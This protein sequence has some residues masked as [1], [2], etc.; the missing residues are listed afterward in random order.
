MNGDTRAI[1]APGA[2]PALPSEPRSDDD[3]E[4][5]A[6]QCARIV[7]RYARTFRIASRLLPAP[8]RRAAFAIYAVCRTADDIVDASGLRGRDSLEA[9]RRFRD[10]AF[11][12]LVEPS[13]QPILR[14]LARAWH[15]FSV[16][17]ET[18]E[19]L[20]GALEQDVRKTEYD[21]WPVLERY[22]QGV[23]GS[24]GAM[25]SA[26]FGA[27][28]TASQGNASI[29]SAARTLGVAMQLTNI[30][31][32]VG[33][34]ADRGRCYVPISE[35]RRHGLDREMVLT[36]NVRRHWDAWRAFMAFQVDR[37][38]ALYRQA[39]PAIRLLHPD[40]RACAS[41]C[42]AGYSRI[43]DAIE[44]ADFDTLSRR[45][46]VSRLRLLAVVWRSSSGRA[47]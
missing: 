5:D 39:V 13:P 10:E 2:E 47:L 37:A 43:L 28:D 46:S 20:F 40:S 8:R 36:G 32:D 15:R 17:D 24:V 6:R 21:D 22:C 14:E 23:A 41:A 44:A 35:L 38:R 30:L 29:V 1:S 27:T 31:R 4:T 12:A 42:A 25:C 34:D 18:L 45:V 7:A 9:L 26:V 11:L 19:E 33:E 16:P 3:T